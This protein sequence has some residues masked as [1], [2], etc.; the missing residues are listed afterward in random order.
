MKKIIFC[1]ICALLCATSLIAQSREVAKKDKAKNDKTRFEQLQE[2]IRVEKIAYFSHELE[3]SAQEAQKF[4]PI[5]DEY[6]EQERAIRDKYMIKD[7]TEDGFPVRPEFLKMSNAEA[8]QALTNHLNE[9]KEVLALQSQYS[10]ELQKAISVQKVLKLFFVE[11]SFMANAIGKRWRD[12]NPN[13]PP[14]PQGAPEDAPDREPNEME[15]R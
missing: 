3:L 12:A 8:Q 11:K 2:E 15:G 7:T 13:R 9:E 6:S 5:Y 10:K 1:A 14:K 4:W